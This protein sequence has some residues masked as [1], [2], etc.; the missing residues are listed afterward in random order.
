MV[1]TWPVQ[2]AAD[3]LLF[4]NEARVRGR[5]RRRRSKSRTL[6]R[7]LARVTEQIE[8]SEP[9]QASLR[10]VL[11]LGDNFQRALSEPQRAGWLAFEEALFE[12]TE[13]LHR[14][15]FEAGVKVGRSARGEHAGGSL[16]PRDS[17]V[18]EFSMLARLL[19]ALARR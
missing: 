17:R 6:E 15:Y 19:V 2:P 7:R 18:D 14:A 3:V 13:R 12:H 4:M 1:S 11:E 10:R 8:H 5:W 9:Y 16:R